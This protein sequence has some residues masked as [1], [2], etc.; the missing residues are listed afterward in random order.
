MKV[1]YRG[2]HCGCVV[3]NSDCVYNTDPGGND[4]ICYDKDH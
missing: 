3:A 2:T 4:Y 1:I